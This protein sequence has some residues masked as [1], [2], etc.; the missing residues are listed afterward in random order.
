MKKQ[1]LNILLVLVMVIG[2]LPFHAVAHDI[3]SGSSQT[4]G[5]GEFTNGEQVIRDMIEQNS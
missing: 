4:K 2:I 1:L 5:Y 3:G